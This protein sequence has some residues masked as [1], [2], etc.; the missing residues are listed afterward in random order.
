[1]RYD[2]RRR[3]EAAETGR[4]P[5][6]RVAAIVRAIETISDEELAWQ[7]ANPAGLFDPTTLS[8]DELEWLIDEFERLRDCRN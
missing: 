8:D 2:L 4:Y 6:T 5:S 3:L 7:C 1:M